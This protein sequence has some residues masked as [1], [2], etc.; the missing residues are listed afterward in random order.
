MIRGSYSD[1]GGEGC[2]LGLR[3][4]R[5]CEDEGLAGSVE[6]EPATLEGEQP[7]SASGAEDSDSGSGEDI[8]E[9]V[10]AIEDTHYSDSGGDGI[11]CESCPG[12]VVLAEEFGAEEGSAGM[13]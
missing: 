1:G 10:A 5:G 2:G 8:V 11:A 9:P 7:L 3:G 12:A 4:V 6:F 13:A